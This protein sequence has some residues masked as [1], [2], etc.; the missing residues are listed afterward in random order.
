MSR[1]HD[2]ACRQDSFAISEK[3]HCS[4][5]SAAD[6]ALDLQ[7]QVF[8]IAITV[9]YSLEN[10]DLVVRALEPARTDSVLVRHDEPFLSS[11]QH[12][13]ELGS[14]SKSYVLPIS[15]NMF[16]ASFNRLFFIAPTTKRGAEESL[17]GPSTPLTA[18][19][20]GQ[21]YFSSVTPSW[22]N[23]RWTCRFSQRPCFVALSNLNDLP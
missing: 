22:V 23:T 13:R 9:R 14:S 6:S 21:S 1:I 2:F 8:K 4:G 17:P 12:G 20:T 3:A 19:L 7:N 11:S 18:S 15:D 10:L 16:A 5:I